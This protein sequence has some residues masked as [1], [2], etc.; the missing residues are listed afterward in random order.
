MRGRFCKAKPGPETDSPADSTLAS[1]LSTPL[2]PSTYQLGRK[3]FAQFLRENHLPA[4]K[5]PFSTPGGSVVNPQPFLS[6][7]VKNLRAK[8]IRPPNGPKKPLSPQMGN[9]PLQN[10]KPPLLAPCGPLLA[11][12]PHKLGYR[13]VSI[14]AEMGLGQRRDTL[15]PGGGRL[16]TAWEK[17]RCP[18][19]SPGEHH[20]RNLPARSA[21]TNCGKREVHVSSR[22]KGAMKHTL[23]PTLTLCPLAGIRRDSQTPIVPYKKIH[24][25]YFNKL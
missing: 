17:R 25:R 11:I 23:I 20:C 22:G 9:R 21:G 13:P 7:P 24:F 1:P 8:G 18:C 15:R 6:Q 3:S 14:A 12:Q 16:G 5:L 19:D 10:A 2:P 4:K